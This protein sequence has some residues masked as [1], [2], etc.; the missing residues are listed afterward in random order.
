M[1][2]HGPDSSFALAARADG[3]SDFATEGEIARRSAA[4]EQNRRAY[5]R[6]EDWR[7]AGYALDLLLETTKGKLRDDGFTPEWIHSARPT[8]LLNSLTKSGFM[9]RHEVERKYGS[10]EILICDWLLHDLGENENITADFLRNYFWT[11][12]IEDSDKT[13]GNRQREKDLAKIEPIVH[14][15]ELLT[16]G[17]K[18]GKAFNT[19]LIDIMESGYAFLAKLGDRCDNLATLINLNRPNWA[20]MED[21]PEDRA[22]ISKYFEK[23]RRYYSHTGFT[24]ST[25]DLVGQ[26]C[27]LHPS[28]KRAFDAMDAVM[29]MNLISTAPIS[30]ITRIIPIMRRAKASGWIRPC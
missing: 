22:T 19:Y 14:D 13:Y 3:I 11:R 5:F 4:Y 30:V 29:D 21:T 2:K 27:E 24:F 7:M 10:Y 8:E 18:G 1:N 25:H 17:K 28:L 26:A 6:S 20:I 15:F 9:N 16:H 23:I 12:I